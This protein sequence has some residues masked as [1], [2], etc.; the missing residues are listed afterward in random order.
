MDNDALGYMVAAGMKLNDTFSFE[1]G[2]GHAQA[3]LD[4]S[5]SH[6]D[7]VASY[8]LQSTVNLAK[9]LFFVPEIGVID[10]KQDSSGKEQSEIRYYGI[11]WQI[12]F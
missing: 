7:D 10:H 5:A 12:N 3:E 6:A 11:K 8:Y 9:G 4:L 1:M 2:Y